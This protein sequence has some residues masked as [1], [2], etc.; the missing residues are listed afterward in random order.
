M[1]GKSTDWCMVRMKS[2][3]PLWIGE[4][5]REMAVTAG[6]IVCVLCSQTIFNIIIVYA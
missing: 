1:K 5:F 3:W 4:Y 2:P 6:L